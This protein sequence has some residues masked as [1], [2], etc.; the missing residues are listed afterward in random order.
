MVITA[1]VL[2]NILWMTH[3]IKSTED[4]AQHWFKN[5]WTLKENASKSPNYSPKYSGPKIA[6]RLNLSPWLDSTTA[7]W[8]KTA[9]T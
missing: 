5:E 9:K 6:P 2:T 4:R 1:E 7:D 3:Q 8:S